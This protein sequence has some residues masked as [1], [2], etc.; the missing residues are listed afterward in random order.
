ALARA[1]LPT[2]A[3]GVEVAQAPPKSG[4]LV[5]PVPLVP[6]A[7]EL[8]DEEGDDETKIIDRM[9]LPKRAGDTLVSA[10]MAAEEQERRDKLAA[11]TVEVV[12][13][14]SEEEQASV[15]KLAAEAGVSFD[16]MVARLMRAGREDVKKLAAEAGVTYEQMVAW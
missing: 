14:L 9:R 13:P 16:E 4:A 7:R 11:E 8:S 1:A 12:V 6:N 15:K 5:P 2:P 3:S 10:I